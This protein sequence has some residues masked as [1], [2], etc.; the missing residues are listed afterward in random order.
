MSAARFPQKSHRS[1]HGEGKVLSCLY[2]VLSFNVVGVLCQEKQMQ[3]WHTPYYDNE[4]KLK[5]LYIK[6]C[7]N[8]PS[9]GCKLYPIR[10]L[11]RGSS[12]RKVSQLLGVGHNKLVLLNMRSK[13]VCQ[14]EPLHSFQHWTLL[15]NECLEMQFRGSKPW[16]IIASSSEDMKSITSALM[17]ATDIGGSLINHFPSNQRDFFDFGDQSRDFKKKCHS[18]HTG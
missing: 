9:Y 8:L 17:E 16:V 4:I 1:K 7:K 5:Q 3:L 12:K 18:T 15:G 10:Q 14:T 2:T 13:T 11:R 6:I